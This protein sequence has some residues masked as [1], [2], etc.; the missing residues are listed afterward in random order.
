MTQLPPIVRVIT[1]LPVGGIERRLVSVLPR[2]KEKGWPVHLILIREEGPLAAELRAKG[3][4]VELIPLKSRLDPVGIRRLSQK[5]Q[6]LRA[7]LVHAHMYRSSVP[8][9]IASRF[10]RV[11]VIFSQVHNVDTWESSRQ[12]SMDRFLSRWRTGTVCVSR[13]V[14][15]D[16]CEVLRLPVSKAPVLYNGCDTEIFKPD[17]EA[18]A[19]TRTGLGLEND[20]VA[21]L[22]P[23]RLHSNK[24]PLG[25]L[26]A[27]LEARRTTNDKAVLLY[28][29]G[30][31]LEAD[32]R[33]GI[34]SAG[35]AEH[36]RLLGRR[37]DMA[38]LYNAADV[39][40][41]SSFKEG[42]SNAVVEALACG[43]P[44]I[45]ADVGGNREAID[46]S[47][48]GWIH[49]AGDH[50]AM[51]RQISE[52]IGIREGLKHRSRACR[53][54]GLVF[55]L[56]QLVADTDALYRKALTEAGVL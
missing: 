24:N 8:A 20:T 30:G 25:V 19:K 29:G 4:P 56:D 2:L 5:L 53:E 35:A 47:E 17:G 51:V 16:V 44:V 43:K 15:Q 31:G 46:S 36:V 41:L 9:T 52:A 42:F 33:A 26:K 7:G 49:T 6:Q 38:G 40:L 13:A 34:D 18:R 22:V 48:V 39:V 28:A 14:Q 1:W 12:A 10:A 11:P 21:V 23:A 50:E 45:A 55:S 27:F 54:R 32:L 3:V 37:D